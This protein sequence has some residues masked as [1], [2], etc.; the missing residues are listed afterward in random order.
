M[1]WEKNRTVLGDGR[2]GLGSNIYICI[3]I[4]I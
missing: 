3:R 1:D 2:A 4:C